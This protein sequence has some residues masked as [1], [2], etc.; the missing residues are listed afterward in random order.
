MRII[1]LSLFFVYNVS[2]ASTLESS[3]QREILFLKT[4]KSQLRKQTQDLEK[5]YI[6]REIA[7][8]Q[9]I[10]NLQKKLI[11]LSTRNDKL[12]QKLSDLDREIEEVVESK[13][14]LQTIVEQS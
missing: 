12:S 8:K 7:A 13:N 9:E 14:Q 6:K 4:Y 11:S 5:S 10:E 3:Y 2:G 1:F